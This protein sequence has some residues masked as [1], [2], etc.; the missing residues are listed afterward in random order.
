[1][2]RP[3]FRFRRSVEF[4]TKGTACRPKRCAEAKSEDSCRQACRRIGVDPTVKLL[5]ADQ[6]VKALHRELEAAENS[7]PW[8]AR[9]STW[10][11]LM[12][13]PLPSGCLTSRFFSKSSS[14]KMPT[15]GM[16]PAQD[17]CRLSFRT[18]AAAARSGRRARRPALRPGS[19][20]AIPRPGRLQAQ[21]PSRAWLPHQTPSALK[22]SAAPLSQRA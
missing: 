17:V 8:P 4:E 3:C 1:M 15:Q 22:M 11:L 6:L 21:S 14:D 13:P 10:A 5:R 20:H 19:K 7:R 18:N 16:A 9:T 12:R 2:P